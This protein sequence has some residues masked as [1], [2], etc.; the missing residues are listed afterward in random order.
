MARTP[1]VSV[2]IPTFNAARFIGPTI[3]SALEQT[4][5]DLELV[6]CDDASTDD[7]I[8]RIADFDDPRIRVT[9]NAANTGIGPNWNRA[10]R[11]CRA[12]LVKLLCQDDLIYPDC[13]EKQAAVLSDSKH[14][15][16][17]LVC[18]RRDIIDETGRVRLRGRGGLP[19]GWIAGKETIRRV[20]RSG[21]NPI[22]EPAAVLFRSGL[23]EAVGGFDGA[24]PY[25]IDVDF[26]CRALLK[27]NLY[28]MPQTL[29]AFRISRGALSSTL[30][31]SQSLQA[32]TF[33]RQLTKE[34]GSPVTQ[35]DATMGQ[36]KATLLAPARRLA[37]RMLF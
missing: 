14:A 22:G 3:R 1:F 30:A 13:L 6:I 15:G 29:S 19:G 10:V 5:P 36:I 2:C 17:G 31:K 4:L 7:T 26:W 12:P 8:K 16:V 24:S 32:R 27:S 34:M 11:E 9:S 35:V 20:A 18:C 33:F 37:Y 25:M 23:F 28:S 21:T